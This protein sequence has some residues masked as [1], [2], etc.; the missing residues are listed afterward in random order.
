ML[1]NTLNDIAVVWHLVNCIAWWPQH[2]RVHG[3]SHPC[4]TPS[5]T[6]TPHNP[7][8]IWQVVTF[9]LST[10]QKDWLQQ[11]ATMFAGYV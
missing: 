3:R 9:W 11:F 2:A 10:M 1:P 8:L 5:P 4:D 7:T 6:L